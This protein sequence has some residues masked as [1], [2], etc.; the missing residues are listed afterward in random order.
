MRIDGN[1]S[2]ALAMRTPANTAAIKSGDATSIVDRTGSTGTSATRSSS[3]VTAA[4]DFS[5]MTRQ[6]LADWMNGKI[7]SGE[8][9]LD[10][11]SAFLGMTMKIP[12]GAGQ[13]TAVALDDQEP[14]NFLQKAQDGIAWARQTNDTGAVKR[15]ET[16][17]NAMRQYQ[18]Q[19]TGVDITV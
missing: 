4:T 9:S 17:L 5:H 15:L 3:S 11:S 7:K 1:A 14:V 13:G 16:A 8:M 6:G 19:V 12:V 10:D 2:Y 18:G